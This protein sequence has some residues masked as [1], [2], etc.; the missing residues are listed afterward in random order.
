[1]ATD[2]ARTYPSEL[3]VLALRETVVFPLTIQPL[4]VN[5]PQSVDAVNRA[6]AGD[7]LLFLS[8][9]PT[10]MTVGMREVEEKRARWRQ[11]KPKKQAELLGN[12]MIPVVLGPGKTHYVIDHHHL[13]RAL[14]Q[15]GYLVIFDSSNAADDVEGFAEIEP[16]LYL[17]RGPESALHA[18]PD[19][20]N[21]VIEPFV[22]V[23]SLC[24]TVVP[25]SVRVWLALC[26]AVSCMFWALER[27]AAKLVTAPNATSVSLL[28]RACWAWAGIGPSAASATSIAT[29]RPGRMPDFMVKTSL[30]IW[31]IKRCRKNGR[32]ASRWWP[33]HWVRASGLAGRFW[34]PEGRYCGV[35]TRVRVPV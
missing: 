32:P 10:Q 18:V 8:L 28:M 9:K 33:Q 12:H 14:A 24:V 23:K 5:R 22:A 7:R 17:Y 20:L 2:S 19:P 30:G 34:Q 6:L 15:L 21:P 4:A 1:M 26:P 13:A 16:N 11:H 3:P 35:T 29:D 25:S 31:L 27:S